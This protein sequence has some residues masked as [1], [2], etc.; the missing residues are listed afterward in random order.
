MGMTTELETLV[1]KIVLIG[2]SNVGK[3]NVVSQYIN[4]EPPK[5]DY[6]T[7]GVEFGCKEIELSNK[8]AVKAQI[9]DT[10]GQERYRAITSA[11]YRRAAGALIVYDVCELSSFLSVETW[12]HELRTRAGREVPVVLVGNKIDLCEN[13]PALRKVTLEEGRK[14]AIANNMSFIETSAINNKNIDEAFEKLLEH[15]SENEVKK[16]KTSGKVLKAKRTSGF[17]DRC[18]A[19]IAYE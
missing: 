15:I 8:R 3:T 5:T 18:S 12:L 4:G 16:I 1:V 19:F 6:A 7:I 9:W 11:H 14:L 2:D 17:I 10:A 13:K